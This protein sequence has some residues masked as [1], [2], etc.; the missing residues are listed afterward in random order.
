MA[1][2]DVSQEELLSEK[3]PLN[4]NFDRYRDS[5][6]EL[7][8]DKADHSERGAAKYSEEDWP[9]CKSPAPPSLHCGRCY[10]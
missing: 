3:G 7:I 4:S 2:L 8:L 1:E 5:D 10:S 9:P 6:D